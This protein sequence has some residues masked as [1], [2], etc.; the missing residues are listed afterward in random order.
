MWNAAQELSIMECNK[1]TL[2]AH[3]AA[4]HH[5]SALLVK[6]KVG[7]DGQQGWF[8]PNDDLRHLEHPE[9]AAKR[10]LAEQVGIRDATLKMVEIE[11]FVG[12]NETW[13]LIFDYL[14][15][16]RTMKISTG[17]EVLE[18]K[19]VEIDE[20]PPAEDFAHHGWG[21]TVLVK[22]ALARVQPATTA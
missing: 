3:V 18:A 12:N 13:H 19:W 14:A 21:R 22:H 6:Y 7:P 8:L 10:I 2:V 4:L 16:P 1:H 9:Q 17:A 5:S 11:S 15:F 20:L